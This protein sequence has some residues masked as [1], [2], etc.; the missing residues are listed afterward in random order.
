LVGAWLVP[1]LAPP[2]AIELV[3][4]LLALAIGVGLL[5]THATDGSVESAAARWPALAATS[6]AFGVAVHAGAQL[7]LISNPTPTGWVLPEATALGLAGWT[8]L[9]LGIGIGLNRRSVLAGSAL[10]LALSGVPLVASSTG[11]ERAAALGSTAAVLVCGLLPRYAAATAGL[12]A[13]DSRVVEGRRWSRLAVRQSVERAYGCLSWSV[14]GVATSIAATSGVLLGSSNRWAVGLGLA[15]VAVTA[16][17]TRAFPLAAQQMALWLAVLVGSIVG[18]YGQYR[19]AAPVAGIGLLVVTAAIVGM[20]AA[21]PAGHVRAGLRRMGDLGEVVA[22][23]SVAPLLLGL[24]GVYQDLLR[25][26][27]S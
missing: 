3:G 27:A 12:T 24:F 16:L 15:V 21:R 5:V 4:A 22:V 6:L 23:V 18:L 17:R 19:L 13:L 10:G 25:A 1:W 20:V 8:C 9:G 2:R 26:F 14:A 7:G 11:P